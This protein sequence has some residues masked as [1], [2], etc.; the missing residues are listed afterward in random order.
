MTI[1]KKISENYKVKQFYISNHFEVKKKKIEVGFD[2]PRL[3]VKP[4]N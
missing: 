4:V 3:K 2:L 1:L